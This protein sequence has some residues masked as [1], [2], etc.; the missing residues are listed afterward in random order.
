MLPVM[1]GSSVRCV[2]WSKVD[3]FGAEL[4]EVRLGADE[5]AATGVAIGSAP[6]PYRLDYSV[7]TLAAFVTSR[8]V[9]PTRGDG[10]ARKPHL[11]R[12]PAGA[13]EERWADAGVG[14]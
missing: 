4:V 5:L 2:A 3:P 10:G 8:V 12:S 1:V 9:G 11:R 7:E 6:M 13:W 14:S